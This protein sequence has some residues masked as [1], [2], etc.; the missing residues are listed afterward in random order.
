M[1]DDGSAIVAWGMDDFASASQ[2]FYRNALMLGV[3]GAWDQNVELK[4]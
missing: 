1:L 3:A 2:S 4:W